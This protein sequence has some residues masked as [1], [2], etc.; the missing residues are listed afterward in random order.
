MGSG[1]ALIVV[2]L[3]L[4][5]LQFSRNM[6]RGDF[7]TRSLSAGTEGVSLSTTY[8]GLIMI[9]IG[10]LLEAVGYAVPVFLGRVV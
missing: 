10:A 1:L 5:I 4:T 9:V 3:V 7:M 2:G 8:V 6:R